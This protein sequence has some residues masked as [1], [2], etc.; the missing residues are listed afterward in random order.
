MEL[1]YWYLDSREAIAQLLSR[2]RT[3]SVSTGIL[4]QLTQLVIGAR[5]AESLRFLP[6]R[7][8]DTLDELR[9]AGLPVSS[10]HWQK[11]SWVGPGI[12]RQLELS[13][14]VSRL[15]LLR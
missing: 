13:E 10:G 9:A 6:Q 1:P 15:S 8:L 11:P 4:S 5:I 7:V 12:C 14:Y 3:G 2:C